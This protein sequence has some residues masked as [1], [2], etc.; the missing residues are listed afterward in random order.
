M[1][2]IAASGAMADL[3]HLLAALPA[4]DDALLLVERLPAGWIA[5]AA[6]SE[7]LRLKSFQPGVTLP[8][9]SRGRVF[10]ADFDCA[11]NRW[12]RAA[13]RRGT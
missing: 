6:L 13:C 12:P 9:P 8:W 5:D 2:E 11:G 4:A 10:G 1:N 7:V 3:A